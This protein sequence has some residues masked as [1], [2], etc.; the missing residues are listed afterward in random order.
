MPGRQKVAK[1]SAARD[2]SDEPLGGERVLAVESG[3]D[4]ALTETI[5]HRPERASRAG[6]PEAA[7]STGSSRRSIGRIR[8]R[9]LVSIHRFGGWFRPLVSEE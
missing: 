4:V 6:S 3:S 1:K 8:A 2:S 9:R 7:A 5:A